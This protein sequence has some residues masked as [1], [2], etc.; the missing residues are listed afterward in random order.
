VLE[1]PALLSPLGRRYI[2]SLSDPGTFFHASYASAHNSFKDA[3]EGV[4]IPR[5]CVEG[6]KGW[7]QWFFSA[8]SE[9][10]KPREALKAMTGANVFQ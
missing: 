3:S 4:D 5:T 1:E 6:V 2:T 9:E 8:N 10:M 7:F